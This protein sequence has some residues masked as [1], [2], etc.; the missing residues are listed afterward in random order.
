MSQIR[1]YTLHKQ[2]LQTDTPEFSSN[3]ITQAQQ[4]LQALS[5]AFET[6]QLERTPLLDRLFQALTQALIDYETSLN[7]NNLAENR[8]NAKP[9]DDH[10]LETL[11]SGKNSGKNSG[12]ILEKKHHLQWLCNQAR[13][14]LPQ[15]YTPP[16]QYKNRALWQI[17]SA[18]RAIAKFRILVHLRTLLPGK[19]P[20]FIAWRNILPGFR[21]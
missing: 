14:H 16:Q 5:V 4:Y 19:A 7:E 21:L 11:N 17:T 10:P 3:V 20:K 18:K 9:I 8:R 1:L 6:K 12:E 13:Y 15:P 2:R